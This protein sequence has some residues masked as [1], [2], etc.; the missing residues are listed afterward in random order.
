LTGLTLQP[1][2]PS[3]GSLA[4]PHAAAAWLTSGEWL[5][6]Q[7]LLALS[8]ISGNNSTYATTEFPVG[9]SGGSGG[10]ASLNSTIN[11]TEPRSGGS[12]GSSGR[13]GSNG[14]TSGNTTG[15]VNTTGGVA[16]SG[17]GNGPLLSS[18]P[19]LT[20]Q[21]VTLVVTP[22]SLALVQQALCTAVTGSFLGSPLVIKRS[23]PAASLTLGVL[24]GARVSASDVTLVVGSTSTNGSIDSNSSGGGTTDS[25]SMY[26]NATATSTQQL[27]DSST[28]AG[29]MS[30]GHGLVCTVKVVGIDSG[31]APV[32][33]CLSQ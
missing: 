32:P 4:D 21:D 30:D 19:L 22:S 15:L 25:A 2:S 13:P 27:N 17:A 8:Y 24:Q 20:L 12:V 6:P 10:P 1:P 9:G 14:T 26:V 11:G 3:F 33:E 5:L 16:G 29:V 7:E 31:E 28:A 18:P 23:I